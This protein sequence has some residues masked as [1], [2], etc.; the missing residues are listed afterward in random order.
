MC[1]LVGRGIEKEKAEEGE[2]I[3]RGFR[4]ILEL[5]PLLAVEFPRSY[6]V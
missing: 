2:R 5:V 4:P 1:G 6:K 3:L